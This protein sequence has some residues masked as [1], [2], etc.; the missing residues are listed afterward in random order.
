MELWAGSETKTLVSLYNGD[1]FLVDCHLRKFLVHMLLLSIILT[2]SY[3]FLKSENV[4]VERSERNESLDRLK[5][6]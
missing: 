2:D 6:R 4:F 1:C 3:L 5:Q